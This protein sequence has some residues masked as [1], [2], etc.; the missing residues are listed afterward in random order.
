VRLLSARVGVVIFREGNKITYLNAL[1]G[2][3]F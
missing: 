2:L 1:L 3:R